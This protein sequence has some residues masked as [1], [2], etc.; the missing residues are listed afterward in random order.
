MDKKRTCKTCGYDKGDKCLILTE[1]IPEDCFAWADEKEVIKR[2]E[3]IRSY[4]EKVCSVPSIHV[5]SDEQLEKRHSVNEFNRKMR[6]G[7]SVK[8]M[9]DEN[10]KKLYKKGLTDTEIANKLY[11][12]K[13][14]VSDYRNKLN[15]PFN[16][17]DRPAAT[18]AEK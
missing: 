8:K 16:K 7:K 3:A 9:L 11:M 10:F 14:R 6:A 17:K 5:Y 12:D 1:K 15:L 18:E 4:N 13:S 2:E